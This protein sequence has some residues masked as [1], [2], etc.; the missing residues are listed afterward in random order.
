MSASTG[1]DYVPIPEMDNPSQDK[2]R[3]A[4]IPCRVPVTLR[5]TD[6]R[7][8]Q[9]ICLDVNQDGIGIETYNQLA[10]GQR[11]ELLVPKGNGDVKTVPMLVMFRMKTHFGL[12]ALAAH[13]HVLDLI[14]TQG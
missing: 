9:A 12:S 6:G 4:R 1:V 7:D 2:R 8:I 3:S 10:V 5:S 14:P 13:E 11:L